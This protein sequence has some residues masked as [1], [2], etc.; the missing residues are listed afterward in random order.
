MSEAAINPLRPQDE[1]TRSTRVR[2]IAEAIPKSAL[3]KTS[4]YMSAEGSE[5][6]QTIAPITSPRVRYVYPNE[7][8]MVTRTRY[9]SALSRGSKKTLH[10]VMRSRRDRAKVLIQGEKRHV[11][12]IMRRL[13][14]TLKQAPVARFSVLSMRMDLVGLPKS[15]AKKGSRQRLMESRR[16]SWQR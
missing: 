4:E 14:S 9:S 2:H 7:V 8:L 15:K 13:Q 16:L 11:D 1:K 12:E 3:K 6:R 10:L 5:C